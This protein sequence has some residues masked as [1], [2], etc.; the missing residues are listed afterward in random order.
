MLTAFET[1][2][3]LETKPVN[4][5]NKRTIYFFMHFNFTHLYLD[6]LE[7]IIIK[8]DNNDTVCTIIYNTNR[9]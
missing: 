8:K 3:Y 9:N 5:N 6:G 2:Y 4:I 1:I 7:I